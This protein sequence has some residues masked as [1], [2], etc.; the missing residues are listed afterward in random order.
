MKAQNGNFSQTYCLIVFK[1]SPKKWKSLNIKSLTLFLLF[2]YWTLS[3]T[4]QKM[5]LISQQSRKLYCCFVTF[6][7][8]QTLLESGYIIQ[9]AWEN[10]MGLNHPIVILVQFPITHNKSIEI[11]RILSPWTPNEVYL[12]PVWIVLK[13]ES[14]RKNFCL[15]LFCHSIGKQG[16]SIVNMKIFIQYI[17]DILKQTGSQ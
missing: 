13:E 12:L 1:D 7:R 4:T 10:S 3:I 9:G 2:R 6:Q 8:A 14:Q 11:D 16:N 5:N 15:K 17:I